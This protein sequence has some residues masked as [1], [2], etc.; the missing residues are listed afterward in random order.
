MYLKF[1]D[2]IFFNNNFNTLL[3]ALEHGEPR[4]KTANRKTPGGVCGSPFFRQFAVYNF[5]PSSLVLL[6]MMYKLHV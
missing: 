2:L 4:E 5:S 3:C 6:Y 1:K